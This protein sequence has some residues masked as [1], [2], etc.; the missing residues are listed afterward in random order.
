MAK[1]R[2]LQIEHEGD[3]LTVRAKNSATRWLGGLFLGAGL[4]FVVLAAS[5]PHTDHM[6][7]IGSVLLFGALSAGCG[8][9]LI[10]PH[11]YTTVFNSRSREIVY[12]TSICNRAPK[13]DHY[14]FEE[15]TGIALNK[16]KMISH[17]SPY[18][19]LNERERRLLLCPANGFVGVTAGVTLLET[20]CAATGLTVL[21]LDLAKPQSNS[22]FARS[23][24][25]V[26]ATSTSTQPP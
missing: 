15:I 6:S 23:M 14:R 1:Y 9:F 3:T 18:L 4:S 22:F 17:C 16:D 8:V 2:G 25:S 13:T 21:D 20:I 12:S 7:H 5:H 11:V 10:V 24:A 26:S 19:Q